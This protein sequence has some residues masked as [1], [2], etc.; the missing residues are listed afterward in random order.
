M[1]LNE[2][3]L[4][5]VCFQKVR[6][7]AE[8]ESG[9]PLNFESTWSS[10]LLV[11]AREG[12]SGWVEE[13]HSTKVASSSSLAHVLIEFLTDLNLSPPLS[14]FWTSSSVVWTSIMICS[15]RTWFNPL[16]TVSLNK[17]R[18]FHRDRQL[19]VV[20]S[21]KVFWKARLAKLAAVVVDPGSKYSGGCWSGEFLKVLLF[22]SV[23]T[24]A[25]STIVKKMKP[26]QPKEKTSTAFT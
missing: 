23:P 8:G 10:D 11:D 25:N 17:L 15:I 3:R 26:R 16:K 9:G 6:A 14:P 2:R 18:L 1:Y 19:T 7:A 24:R 13:G 21:A 22:S 20:R 12:G 4:M 5:V